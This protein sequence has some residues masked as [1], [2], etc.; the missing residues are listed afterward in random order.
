MVRVGLV[1]ALA[2]E[3]IH[4]LGEERDDDALLLTAGQALPDAIVLG[5]DDAGAAEL[6]DRLRAAAPTAKLILL[7]RDES[8]SVVLDPRSMTPRAIRQPV[9]E[10]LLTELAASRPN[11]KE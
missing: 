3:G 9:S 8:G 10:A 1:C 7:P 2:D 4:V 6:G 11:S 5:S